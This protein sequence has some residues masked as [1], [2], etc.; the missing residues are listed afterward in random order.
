MYRNVGGGGR[1]GGVRMLGFT[2]KVIQV[3]RHFVFAYV[4]RFLLF[5]SY[6]KNSMRTVRYF[7]RGFTFERAVGPTQLLGESEKLV[8]IQRSFVKT[9]TG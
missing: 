8:N 3:F 4:E 2:R 6:I 7:I 5:S 1:G 9:G